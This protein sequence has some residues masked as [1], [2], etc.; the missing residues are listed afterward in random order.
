MERETGYG[1]LTNVEL[2]T[3]A[4]LVAYAGHSDHSHTPGQPNRAHDQVRDMGN[5]IKPIIGEVKSAYVKPKF[6]AFLLMNWAW[7]RTI[8]PYRSDQTIQQP[9]GAQEY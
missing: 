7:P 9:S 6:M 8:I 2:V 3:R 4:P 5:D 1:G